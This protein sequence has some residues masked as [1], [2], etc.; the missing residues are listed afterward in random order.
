MLAFLA[1]MGTTTMHVQDMATATKFL[2]IS[3]PDVKNQT[4]LLWNMVQI[5]PSA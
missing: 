4:T 2:C 3:F 5:F 1:G